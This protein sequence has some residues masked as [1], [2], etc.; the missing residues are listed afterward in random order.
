MATALQ[1]LD[2]VKG[3]EDVQTGQRRQGT[4]AHDTSMQPDLS[5]IRGGAE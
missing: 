4:I 5:M 1:S 2:V 3:I